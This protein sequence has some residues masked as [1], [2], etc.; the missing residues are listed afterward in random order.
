LLG[1]TDADILGRVIEKVSGM[2]VGE[3]LAERVFA[4]LKL[5]DTAFLVPKDKVARLAQPFAVDKET[6]KP[7]TLFDVTVAHKNDAGRHGS[8]GTAGD[9]ARFLQM[10]LK[11]EQLD[12][13]R[14]LSR[15]TVAYMTSDHLDIIKAAAV[16]G[17]PVPVGPEAAAVMGA[18][19]PVGPGANRVWPS[20]R[21]A[22]GRR[23]PL[24]AGSPR[25]S[26]RLL[27]ETF[28]FHTDSILALTEEL[29]RSDSEQLDKC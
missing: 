28:R 2:S 23:Q 3:F 6:G 21:P 14:L 15:P 13:A 7:I 27:S 29:G 17:A 10:M 5:K 8:A 24:R 19:V 22:R 4:S 18:P 26:P 16:M 11:G 1:P 20:P 9:Y 12:G 25:P